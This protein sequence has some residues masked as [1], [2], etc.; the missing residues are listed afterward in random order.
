MKLRAK[1]K[2][3][4]QILAILVIIPSFLILSLLYYSALQHVNVRN[5][6]LEQ[7]ALSSSSTIAEKIDRN[8]YERCSNVKAFAY[9][10][11]AVDAINKT[12]KDSSIQNYM[13]TMIDY[14]P[15]YDLTMLCDI[16]GK[17]IAVNTK[18]E[19]KN[20]ISTHIFINK[21]MSGEEWFRSS[22]V[23][24]GPKG[25]VY[26]SDFNEDESIG[27]LY[28]NKG[29]GMNF[30]APVR[31]E[32]G[33]IIG[34]WRNHAGWKGIAQEARREAEKTLQKDIKGA[35]VLVM[36]K[37]GNLIDAEKEENILKVTI[38][39]NNLLKKFNFQYS[40]IN[41]NDEDYIYGWDRER[42]NNLKERKWNFLTLIPKVKLMDYDIY[43]NSD[44]TSLMVFSVSLLLSGIFISL[45]FVRNFSKRMTLIKESVLQL[46]KGKTKTIEK[47]R[48]KDEI[49]EMALAINTLNLNFENIADFS[50]QIGKGN[51][52]ASY[53]LLGEEDLLGISLL[54]MQQNLKVIENENHK[55]KWISGKLTAL[56]ELIREIEEPELKFKKLISFL[57]KSVNANQGA[58]FVVNYSSYE[59]ELKAG[60][61]LTYKRTNLPPVIWGENTI[62]QCIKDNEM[63][64]LR[65]LPEDYV[66]V[67]Q[68]GLG[69]FTPN[70]IIL[71]PMD[72]N[73]KVEGAIEFSSF[74]LFD[75]YKI[76]FLE[77]VCE[78][79]AS[80]IAQNRLNE[81]NEI[82]QQRKNA[83]ID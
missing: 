45:L 47:I 46:A 67:I 66:H 56:G 31:D 78:Y 77:K 36:D 76:Q 2:L 13:N 6:P 75:D 73:N 82:V 29:Y 37:Q 63:I 9:N 21:N 34:V 8:L 4:H 60:Y 23:V 72:Y 15:L 61:A 10:K 40:T 69:S 58:L 51:L 57:S 64:R 54:K 22:I 24:G 7:R 55:Q 80:Y 52:S 62:G 30:S 43:V 79:I 39:K 18:N 28:N 20:P 16:T 59:I 32:K 48:S 49:G 26:Y 42:N 3:S 50:N 35:I 71:L 11:L 74:E 44:W 12:G 70:E 53:Q 68:S 83:L 33:N 17:V 25:G 81:Q 27:Q 5:K 1:L 19:N 41:I 14:Y 65:N 38:G